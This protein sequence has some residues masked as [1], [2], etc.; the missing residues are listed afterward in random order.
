MKKNIFVI[1]LLII[2]LSFTSCIHSFYFEYD[3]LI[4]DVKNAE[5]INLDTDYEDDDDI[6]ILF[7]F[8]YDETLKLLD[9][10]SK[11]EYTDA[12]IGPGVPPRPRGHCIR[13]WYSD[14]HCDVYGSSGT[15]VRWGRGDSDAFNT[16]IDK[17]ITVD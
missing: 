10:F 12:P 6:E 11:I 3:E 17:Y 16:L 13:V 7:V 5:I 15:S 8:D 9:E 14:G 1:V 4:K 2:L